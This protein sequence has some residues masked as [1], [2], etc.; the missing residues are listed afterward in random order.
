M[1]DIANSLQPILTKG[2]LEDLDSLMEKMAKG[3]LAGRGVVQVA[4]AA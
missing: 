3:Q 1:C 2:K 4:S